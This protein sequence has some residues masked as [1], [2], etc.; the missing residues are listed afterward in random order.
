[1]IIQVY[2]AGTTTLVATLAVEAANAGGSGPSPVGDSGPDVI[3]DPLPMP[4]EKRATQIEPLAF[5]NV[6]FAAERGNRTVTL[7][8]T[9]QSFFSTRDKA[10]AWALGST[11]S[12]SA[13]DNIPPGA[14]YDVLFTSDDG[15]GASKFGNGAT[16]AIDVVSWVGTNVTV[17]YVFEGLTPP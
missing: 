4:K 6:P 12:P 15:A 5:G 13:A 16:A 14:N 17:R 2:A 3:L 9:V 10:M 7:Q 8:F 1:M 11:A